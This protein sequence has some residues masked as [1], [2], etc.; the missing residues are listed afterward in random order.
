MQA[1][2]PLAIITSGLLLARCDA[3]LLPPNPSSLAR[4]ILPTPP[5][6]VIMKVTPER[7]D[8]LAGFLDCERDRRSLPSVAAVLFSSDGKVWGTR[9]G[10]PTVGP[11]LSPPRS[12]TTGSV[13][14]PN[15]SLQLPSP[16]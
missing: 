10:S 5:A 9:A 15:S 13:Q 8:D 14:S 11:E 7:H 4:E 3:R 1:R 2:A 12:T 6:A 16:C